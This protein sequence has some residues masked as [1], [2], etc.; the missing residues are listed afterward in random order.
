[1]PE[2]RTEI[3]SVINRCSQENGSN[4]PD[5]ILAS[6]LTNCLMAFDTAVNAREKWYGREEGWRPPVLDYATSF[7]APPAQ[8]IGAPAQTPSG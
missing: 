6:F 4:T 8:D 1:M 2:F 3:E 5:F 7:P